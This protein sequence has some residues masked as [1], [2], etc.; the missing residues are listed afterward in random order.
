MMNRRQFLKNI[1]L[2]TAATAFCRDSY[3]M[4]ILANNVLNIDIDTRGQNLLVIHCDELSFRTLGCYRQILP[5]DQT[6]MWGSGVIVETPNIDWIANNGVL[7]KHMYANSPIC[8][9]SRASLISGKY[10]QNSG[11]IDNRKNFFP[12]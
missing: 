8:S 12:M 1:G 2:G 10:P 9:P 5:A 11:M 3:G 7:C 6:E 4:K